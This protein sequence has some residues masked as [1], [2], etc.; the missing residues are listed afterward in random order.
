MRLREM[1]A[2]QETPWVKLGN[3]V[4][5]GR[6]S[7][8]RN[9][10]RT[11]YRVE[12]RI[13][14]GRVRRAVSEL[15]GW[16]PRVQADRLTWG[17]ET[18]EVRVESVE[19]ETRSTSEDIASVRCMTPQQ[20]GGYHPG[21]GM[22]ING[23]GP[24]EQAEIWIRRAVLG[25]DVAAG[26]SSLLGSVLEPKG[27]SLAEVLAREGAQGWLAEGLIRLY[28]VEGLLTRFGGHFERL[29]VGPAT[30]TGVRI[31]IEFVPD[32]HTTTPVR[33]SGQVQLA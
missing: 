22:T 23:V 14:D 4:F 31:D 19:L 26:R 6:V 5:P 15:G 24:A 28:L 9:G 1:A 25:E 33:L 32:A 16:S 18:Q 8:R 29:D 17:I 13:R 10:H 11:E 3:L 7:R 12:A 21:M 27:P 2:A 20:G 30:S